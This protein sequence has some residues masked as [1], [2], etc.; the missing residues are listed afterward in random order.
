MYRPTADGLGGNDDCGQMSAW[1]IFSSLGFYPM[2]PG[3][4]TY[5]LGSPAVVNAT[6]NLENGKTFTVKT[7]NQSDKNV[8]VSKVLLNGK[9]LDRKTINHDEI[10]NGGQIEF[11]MSAKPTTK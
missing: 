5:E 6:I 1:F 7:K 2:A 3:A 9:V 11:F 10:M 4:L 8:Y